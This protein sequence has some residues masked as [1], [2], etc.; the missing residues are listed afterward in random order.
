MKNILI[1][2]LIIAVV[3]SFQHAPAEAYVGLV[4]IAVVVLVL[5]AMFISRITRYARRRGNHE[6]FTMPKSQEYPTPEPV[7]CHALDVAAD[8]WLHGDENDTRSHA[9]AAKQYHK[10][11]S[12]AR[13]L[14][15]KRQM[16]HSERTRELNKWKV[17]E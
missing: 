14:A 5:R 16:R 13:E 8:P 12:E 11:E 2:S 9:Y 17:S 15:Y 3:F 4:F 7:Q 6:Y 1:G 10:R